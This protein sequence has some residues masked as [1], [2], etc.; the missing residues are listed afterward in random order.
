M[1]F[2]PIYGWNAAPDW[3]TTELLVKTVD[4]VHEHI[5]FPDGIEEVSITWLSA[6]IP[7]CVSAHAIPTRDETC[8]SVVCIIAPDAGR[9]SIFLELAR[10]LCCVALNIYPDEHYNELIERAWRVAALIAQEMHDKT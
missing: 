3:F 2:W 7:A 1:M 6:D 8:W 10:A 4:L 9:Y 5:G